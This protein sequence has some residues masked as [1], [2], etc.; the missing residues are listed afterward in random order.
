MNYNRASEGTE[1]KTTPGSQGGKWGFVITGDL[2]VSLLCLPVLGFL[3]L[4]HSPRQDPDYA[5]QDL[6]AKRL[7]PTAPAEKQTKSKTKNPPPNWLVPGPITVPSD[8]PHVHPC[9]QQLD[10]LPEQ[11]Q[12]CSKDELAQCLFFLL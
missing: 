10:L 1:T 9:G 8:R 6:R 11:E 12:G 2:L 4:F 3:Y 5:I 7:T